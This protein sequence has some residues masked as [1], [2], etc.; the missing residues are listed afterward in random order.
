M[1]S[2]VQKILKYFI[3]FSSLFLSLSFIPSNNVRTSDII[4]LSTI[5]VITFCVLDMYLPVV[6]CNK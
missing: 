2:T 5:G 4:I 1:D 6:I 3:M